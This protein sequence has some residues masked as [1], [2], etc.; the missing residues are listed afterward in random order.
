MASKVC[1]LR[2]SVPSVRSKAAPRSFVWACT[3]ADPANAASAI[4]RHAEIKL[5]IRPPIAAAYSRHGLPQVN[6]VRIPEASKLRELRDLRDET[7]VKSGK[8]RIFATRQ[9]KGPAEF[10]PPGLI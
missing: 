9:A 3:V 10:L 6:G 4:A 1:G 2:S 7:G 8:S 5:F